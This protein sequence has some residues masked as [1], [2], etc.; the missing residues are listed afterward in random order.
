VNGPLQLAIKYIA[1]NKLKTLILIGCL[2]L[3]FLLPISIKL[4]LHQ[5]NQ[6]IMLRADST[7][8]IVGAKGSPLDLTLHSLYY[9]TAAPASVLQGEVERIRRT[10]LAAAIPLHV[11]F[12]ARQF[13]IVGTSTD[14][15]NFRKLNMGQ[16]NPF[17]FLGEC[18]IGST[19][20]HQLKLGVGDWLLSDRE[21]V[22]D[23]AGLY[24][25]KMRV[26]GVLD[27]SRTTDDRAVFVDL[28]TAWVI[29]GLGHGHQDLSQEE[30][31]GKILSRDKTKIVASAAVLPFTEVTD[32]NR[33]SFHFHG[34]TDQFPIS[35]IIAIPHDVKSQTL[36]EGQYD[37]GQSKLQLVRP[38]VVVRELMNMVFRIKLFFDAN[39]IMIAVST[40]LLMV[41]V[42]LLSLRLRK[43]EMETMFKIGCS[44]GTIM[45]LQFWEL[46]LVFSVALVLVLL[47]TLAI[48]S[49]SGEFVETMM[50]NG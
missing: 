36:L 12:T 28:K 23:L 18:V 44:R 19:V 13:P 14:Y 45:Q 11:K 2:F 34:S 26:V 7:P 41:L 27:A 3:T 37:V 32:A 46:A 10:G 22:I 6:K 33:D 8:T 1:F 9:K 29:Q 48:W 17:T 21:N 4:L 30:D 16:G 42:V 24:P 47:A 15:F 43:R 50:L 40:I 49:V 20:A 5:F 38:P 39:A 35:A 25:L 31:E